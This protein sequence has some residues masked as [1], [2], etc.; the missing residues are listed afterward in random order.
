ML[1]SVDHGGHVVWRQERTQNIHMCCNRHI[2]TSVSAQKTAIYA[3][4]TLVLIVLLYCIRILSWQ[5]TYTCIA[6]LRS[7]QIHTARERRE[8]VTVQELTYGVSDTCIWSDAITSSLSTQFIRRH[9]LSF[10]NSVDGKGVILFDGFC[11]SIWWNWLVVLMT[12]TRKSYTR[13]SP[14][15]AIDEREL[16]KKRLF[17]CMCA[18]CS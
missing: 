16:G 17:V 8:I 14:Y 18:L 9:G 5:S 2:R 11:T 13:K 7:N 6:L 3:V 12:G 1:T 4:T 15:L 10:L